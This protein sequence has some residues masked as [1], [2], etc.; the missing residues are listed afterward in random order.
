MLYPEHLQHFRPPDTQ[1][2]FLPQPLFGVTG[3]EAG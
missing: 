1:N 3:I 2:H